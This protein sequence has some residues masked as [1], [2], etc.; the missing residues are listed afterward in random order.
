MARKTAADVARKWK[1]RM[2]GASQSVADGVN[3]VTTAPGKKAAAAKDTMRARLLKSIDDGTWEKNT[4]AVPL[5]SWK[6]SMVSKGVPRIADGV[7]KAQ[8]K[9]ETFYSEFLPAVYAA[10]D[11]V[12]AMPNATDAQRDARMMENVKRLRQFKRTRR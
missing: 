8:G 1:E 7:A 9:Q 12:K 4:A 6:D 5:E 11:A 2:E 10:Q 3:A